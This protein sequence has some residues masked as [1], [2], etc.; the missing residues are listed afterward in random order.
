VSAADRYR[1]KE[2][3]FYKLA[4]AAAGRSLRDQ[5]ANLVI[6]YRHLAE[7]ADR[8]GVLDVSFGLPPKI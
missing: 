2:Q 6:A 7:E 4:T 5:Y 3:E 1:T 8:N